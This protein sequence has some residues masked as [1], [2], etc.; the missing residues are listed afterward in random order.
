MKHTRKSLV[1][2]GASLLLS[3]AL[4]AGSTFAWFTDSV[5][6]T[7]NTIEAGTLDVTF[8]KLDQETNSYNTVENSIPIFD[9]TLWEPGY[10]VSEAFKIGNAGSLSLKYQLALTAEGELTKLANVIDVYYKASNT[11]ITKEDLASDMSDLDGYIR[12][13]TLAEVLGEENIAA[14]GHIEAEEADYAAVILHMQE[15]ANDDYQGLSLF[16]GTGT[17][18][19]TLKATQY[20]SEK[21]GFGNDQYDANAGIAWDGSSTDTDWFDPDSTST[22]TYSLSTPEEF[23]GLAKLVSEGNTFRGKTITLEKNINLGNNEWTPIGDSKT[24]FSGIFDGNGKTISG[25]K[26]STTDADGVGLF[27][28]ANGAEFKNVVLDSPVV[29]GNDYVGSVVGSGFTSKITNCQVINPTITGHQWVGGVTGYSYADI[30]RCAVIGGTIERTYFMGDMGSIV[31]QLISATMS[32]CYSTATLKGPG[33]WDFGGLV[34]SVSKDGKDPTVMNCYYAGD[35][36][37]SGY[38]IAGSIRNSGTY[39]NN[40]YNSDTVN[41]VE[42]THG[43][44]PKTTEELKTAATF[45]SYDPAIWNI[46]DGAYPVLK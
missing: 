39:T 44:I 46:V 1:A 41:K 20:T 45:E 27:G 25:L 14:K 32:N 2:S 12:V 21:D 37:G 33:S 19:I 42:T 7:G 18:D 8:E 35:M 23:A 6:N 28:K 11:A 17:F 38:G 16:E 24:S 3:A 5:T 30:S 22:T 36:Q 31:G 43:G 4:L 40:F 15:G 9:Y 26:V 29:E 34:G 13:G 10:S